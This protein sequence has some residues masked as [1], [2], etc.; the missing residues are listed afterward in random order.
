MIL[1]EGDAV[2]NDTKVHNELAVLSA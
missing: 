1:K 2:E